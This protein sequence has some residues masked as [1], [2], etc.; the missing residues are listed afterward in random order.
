MAMIYMKHYFSLLPLLVFFTTI[1]LML[2]N[3]RVN[4]SSISSFSYN[5]FTMDEEDLIF[6]GDAHLLSTHHLFNSNVVQL[7]K[8][9]RSGEP[10]KN[11]VGRVLYYA[12]IQLYNTM[13]RVSN[14]ESNI[15]FILTKPSSKPADGLAFFIAPINNRKIPM[16]SKGGFLG[17]FNETTAFNN[18]SNQILAIEFDTY[19]NTWDPNYAHIG[20]NINS[21]ESLEHVRWEIKEG[22]EFNARIT[23]DP[24]TG[25]LNVTSFYSGGDKHYD[26][27]YVFNLRGV[28]PEWVVVGLTASSGNDGVQVHTILSWDFRSTLVLIE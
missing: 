16:D 12:P 9:N 25:N 23:H 13:G 5:G 8:T 2:L 7:T 20:I 26:V 22:Q 10:Q 15:K 24:F 1:F 18:P 3:M 21:I 17:L 11:T 28:L 6:Q 14:F 19:N 27:S 4:S